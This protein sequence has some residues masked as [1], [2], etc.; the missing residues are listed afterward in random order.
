[1]G[2]FIVGMIL[3]IIV[4]AVV[5]KMIKDK[6]NGKGSCGCGCENCSHKCH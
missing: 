5:A 3:L 4:A 6:K 2:T 1:M